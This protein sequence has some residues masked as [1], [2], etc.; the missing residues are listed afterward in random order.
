MQLN[1]KHRKR[2]SPKR[3]SPIR[4]RRK[5]ALLLELIVS[6]AMLAAILLAVS[7][8]GV[9]QNRQQR[10]LEREVVASHQLQNLMETYLAKD[11]D[12]I[13][14][15]VDHELALPE[16]AQ[17][18]LPAHEIEVLVTEQDQELLEKRIEIRL[19]WG[20]D[21]AVTPHVKSLTCWTYGQSEA[22]P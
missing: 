5:G 22:T 10:T 11:W 18:L 8:M 3:Q 21:Q 7:K 14:Q 16:A 20:N 4:Q 15:N 13:A 6:A 2:L 1:A 17:K 9:A 19:R 12:S